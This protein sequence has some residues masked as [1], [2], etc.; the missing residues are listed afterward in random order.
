MN[1]LAHE[2]VEIPVNPAP[3]RVSFNIFMREEIHFRGPYTDISG[4]RVIIIECLQEEKR[5][6]TKFGHFRR[7]SGSNSA[8]K[9]RRRLPKDAKDASR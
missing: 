9:C 4:I 1:F 2:N 6:I 3:R 8:Q 5:Y 7:F